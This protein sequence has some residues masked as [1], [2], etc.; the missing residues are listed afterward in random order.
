MRHGAAETGGQRLEP[1][2]GGAG[3][4]PG[5]AGEPFHLLDQGERVVPVGRVVDQRPGGEAERLLA[6]LADLGGRAVGDQP[7]EVDGEVLGRSERTGDQPDDPAPVE[8]GVGVGAGGEHVGGA[9]GAAGAGQGAGREHGPRVEQPLVRPG[10][11]GSRPVGVLNGP[12]VESGGGHAASSP[13]MVR[14]AY[15]AAAIRMPSDQAIGPT[16]ASGST[17]PSGPAQLSAPVSQASYS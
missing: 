9:V 1:V 17:R 4:G 6:D 13:S 7:E 10:V 16:S 12:L 5:L 11:L 2:L 8:R 15:S 3:L 14:P